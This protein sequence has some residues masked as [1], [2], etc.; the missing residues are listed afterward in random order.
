MATI[1][2]SEDVQIGHILRCSILLPTFSANCQCRA[3]KVTV[4]R[5]ID[6]PLP[7]FSPEKTR[8]KRTTETRKILLPL[9]LVFRQSLTHYFPQ[10]YI[11]YFQ[12][13]ITTTIK[14]SRPLRLVQEETSLD[15]A[16]KITG[17]NLADLRLQLRHSDR[18]SQKLRENLEDSGAARLFSSR[19]T[20]CIKGPHRSA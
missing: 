15:L 6:R 18:E 2:L 12:S 16:Q 17:T 4:Q 11:T 19:R 20:P 1:Y 10:R 5:D 3:F 14:F 13:H 8:T 9:E 7:T